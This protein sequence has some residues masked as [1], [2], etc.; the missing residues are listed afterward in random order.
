MEVKL[1]GIVQ[2]RCQL[3]ANKGIFMKK[4]LHKYCW[5][6]GSL[7][8]VAMHSFLGA[9]TANWIIS[10][11][12]MST[13]DIF[14]R[15]ESAPV[16]VTHLGGDVDYVWHNYVAGEAKYS[17]QFTIKS[18]TSVSTKD[19]PLPWT[20]LSNRLQKVY[21]GHPGIYI[22]FSTPVARNYRIFEKNEN[23]TRYAMVYED[24]NL[25]QRG[26]I[27]QNWEFRIVVDSSGKLKLLDKE[28]RLVH[29][30]ISEWEKAAKMILN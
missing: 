11:H 3:V 28:A 5:Y 9:A 17:N 30:K 7:F 22:S 24:N 16:E 14:V 25:L 12:N 19:F 8:F 6:V 20:D 10:F 4:K 21:K 13:S 27:G 18:A 23:G 29:G 2:L 1:N 26:E 15:H